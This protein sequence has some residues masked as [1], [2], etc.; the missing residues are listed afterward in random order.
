[1]KSIRILVCADAGAAGRDLL[2]R[3]DVLLEWALTPEEAVAALQGGPPDV[4]LAREDFVLTLLRHGRKV[5]Q[6]TPVIVLLESDGWERRDAFFEAGA[7]ALVRASN[8]ERI[9]EALSELTGLSTS[10]HPR[11][12]YGDVVD[13]GIGGERRFYEAVELSSS[14]ISVRD[15][16]AVE[17]GTIVDVTLVMMDPPYTFSAMVIRQQPDR[18]GRLSSLA[19]NAISDDE[20]AMLL[21]EIA[22][23]R[24]ALEPLPEPVGLTTDLSG[25]TYTLDLFTAMQGESSNARYHRILMELLEAGEDMIQVRSPRW[26][27]RVCRHLSELERRAL[28]GGPAPEYALAALDM[29]IDLAHSRAFNLRAVPSQKEVDL[30]LDFCRALAVDSLDSD[31]EDLAQVAAIR[32]ELLREVY[33]TVFTP[34]EE[35]PAHVRERLGE[36]ERATLD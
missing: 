36:E 3:R 21:D 5:V 33:G 23:K 19:F 10:V 24:R 13:V 20:R 30:C 8:R 18:H 29:R 9:L 28:T 14:G 7:T 35:V 32:A 31:V 34:V 15:L 6:G 4:I 16:P 27:R 22:H 25:S 2:A 26:L 11:V 17:L 1:M 12:P